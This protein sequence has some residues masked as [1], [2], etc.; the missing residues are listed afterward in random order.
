MV[1]AAATSMDK[2]MALISSP[3]TWMI[4]TFIF[5]VLCIILVWVLVQLGK[6]THAFQ[7]WKAVRKKIPIFLFFNDD[8]TVDFRPMVPEAGMV[9]SKK[10]GAI[11]INSQS[12]YLDKTTNNILIPCAGGVGVSVPV[13]FAQ[14]TDAVG[15]VIGDEKKLNM[16]R[17]RIMSNRFTAEQSKGKI[18]YLRESVNFSKVKSFMNTISPHNIDAKINLMVSRKLGSFGK[19]QMMLLIGM[20]LIGLAL[21]ALFA[22]VYNSKTN[23][24]VVIKS[25]ETGASIIKANATKIIS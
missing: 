4:V 13:K 22:F 5:F 1:V 19:D 3:L 16:L 15:K 2:I 12:N 10:Y 8:N 23:P 24:E 20:L 17:E 7:E 18:S 9:I 6:K 25:I 11:I 14:F 21:I